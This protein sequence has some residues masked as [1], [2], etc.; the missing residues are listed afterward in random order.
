MCIKTQGI[1]VT[2]TNTERVLNSRPALDSAVV[3]VYENNTFPA[4]K[5][6]RTLNFRISLGKAKHCWDVA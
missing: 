2:Q 6:N 4:L 1:S 3:T 5:G